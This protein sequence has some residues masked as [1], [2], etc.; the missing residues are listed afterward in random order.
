M[1]G[2]SGN[3]N[4]N[5]GGLKDLAG[6]VNLGG[7][8]S[9]NIVGGGLGGLKDIGGNLIGNASSLLGGFGGST[10]PSTRTTTT[11][12]TSTTVTPFELKL[13]EQYD[14]KFSNYELKLKDQNAQI[15]QY[16]QSIKNYEYKLKESEQKLA[17]LKFDFTQKY[18]VLLKERN[19]IAQERDSFNFQLDLLRKENMQL[20]TN[21]SQFEQRCNSLNER[22]RFL[23]G[24]QNLKSDR[25]KEI[26]SKLIAANNSINEAMNLDVNQEEIYSK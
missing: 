12:T 19:Y 24:E 23:E 16:D 20:K 10:Q 4:V 22:V 13:K 3:V 17:N 6:G 9:S 11:T 15:L 2:F 21:L 25:M 26:E 18:D 14:T 7:N 1:F 8:T 5:L